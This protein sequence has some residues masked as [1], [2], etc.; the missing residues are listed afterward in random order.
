MAAST[1]DVAVYI[2]RFQPF[3]N[4]HLALLQ[5]A[6]QRGK[7][8]V[9]VLGSAFRAR[10]VKNPFTWEERAAMIRLAVSPSDAARI[11]FVP[12]RDYHD[13]ECWVSAVSAGV[14]EATENARD[15]CLVGHFKDDSSYY[16]DRFPGWAQVSCGRQGDID[17]TPLRSALFGALP[18]QC[19][20]ALALLAMHIPTAVADFLHAWCELPHFAALVEE[21][22][23]LK[24]DKAKWAPAP[25]EP[26]FVTVDSVV[27]C[28][29]HVLL[30]KRGRAPGKGLLALPGGFLEPNET[31]YRGAIRELREETGFGLADELLDTCFRR[32]EVFDHPQRSLRGRTITHAH[33]FSLGGTRLPEVHGADDA[34]AAVWVPLHALADMEDQFFEDHFIILNFFLK[35]R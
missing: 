14:A 29:D 32:V 2:G 33:L 10:D 26:M 13:D 35:L 25:H 5:Q 11:R 18:G 27:V 23:K 17:A 4:G 16:L 6:L 20:G 7:Q 12:V 22:A 9:V 15:I 24:K 1:H 8:V 30:V 3:H 28:A 31:L 21:F 19:E 34:E